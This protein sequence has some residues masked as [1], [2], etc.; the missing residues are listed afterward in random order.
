MSR[1]V[2]SDWTV[3]SATEGGVILG[4]QKPV[5]LELTINKWPYCVSQGGYDIHDGIVFICIEF[6]GELH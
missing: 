3:E 5:S 1:T 2:H 4:K 6:L